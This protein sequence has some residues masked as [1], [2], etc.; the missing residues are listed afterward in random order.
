MDTHLVYST[1][2]KGNLVIIKAMTVNLCNIK[3]KILLKETI[4]NLLP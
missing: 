2:F 3:K 4:K 1:Q